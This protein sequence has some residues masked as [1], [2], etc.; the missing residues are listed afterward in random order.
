MSILTTQQ[1]PMA[2]A[3]QQSGFIPEKEETTQV[4]D[5][6]IKLLDPD[7]KC[8][9]QASPEAAGFDIYSH[10]DLTIAPGEQS[11][12]GTKIALEIPLGYHGQLLVQSG[13]AAK[14]CARVEAGVIDSDYRG[15]VYVLISNNGNKE[16]VISKGD[17]IAQMIIVQDP[18][19]SLSVTK[20]LSTTARD[21]AGFGST[22]LK[23][24]QS[25]K[26]AISDNQFQLPPLPTPVSTT[27]STATMSAT[28]HEPICNIDLLPDPF[29][30]THTIEFSQ[31]GKHPT[32]GLILQESE[33][34]N[35]QV[36]IIS[37]QAGTA[38]SKIRNW[39]LHLKF[40]T[41]LKINNIDITSVEQATTILSSVPT[42]TSIEIQ[43]GLQSK[44]PMHEDNIVPMVYFDQ[45]HT[46]A[47]H[48]QWEHK[49]KQQPLR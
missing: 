15:E 28:M 16:M 48:L 4:C 29:C 5:L 22:G 44:V 32:Q 38:A 47:T 9:V 41:L 37:C 26:D 33:T 18:S 23:D 19:V 20:E 46:I 49:M 14:Y 24:I 25:H 11:K 2:T 27:A 17:Q 31:Q 7:A 6:K 8:P 35:E 13:Y 39:R 1:P 3:L 45:L 21:K 43:V 30:D 36:Q 12:I 10:E 42:H 34:W 40:S